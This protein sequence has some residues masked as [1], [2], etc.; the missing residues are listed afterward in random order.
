[1]TTNSDFLD[2]AVKYYTDYVQKYPDFIKRIEEHHASYEANHNYYLNNKKAFR[3]IYAK[4][5]IFIYS[6][7]VIAVADSTD[8]ICKK[9]FDLID[10]KHRFDAV[11][12]YIPEVDTIFI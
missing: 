5:N 3:E 10:E 6:E 9:W 12:A 8:E 4:N 7:K 1:M 2:K 11:I